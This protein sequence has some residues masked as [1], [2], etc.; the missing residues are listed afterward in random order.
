MVLGEAEFI[1]FRVRFTRPAGDEAIAPAAVSI[2]SDTLEERERALVIPL[3]A[4]A[5]VPV[6][7]VPTR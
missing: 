7:V 2:T 5:T 3:V 4:E 6:L 1:S